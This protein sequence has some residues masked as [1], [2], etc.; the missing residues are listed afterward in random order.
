MLR[1]PPKA[2]SKPQCFSVCTPVMVDEAFI[3][4]FPELFHYTNLDA[5]RNIYS[6]Q[7]LW[8]SHYEFLNDTSEMTHFESVLRAKIAH[9][10]PDVL[11]ELSL[12]NELH[13]QDMR[14]EESHIYQILYG[15][16]KHKAF[17]KKHFDPYIVSFCAHHQTE[18]GEAEYVL[19]NGLLSQWI[20]YGGV[21]GCALVFDTRELCAAIDEEKD[22]YLV[23]IDIFPMQYL[24]NIDDADHV[25]TNFN[26]RLKN[27][28]ISV[29]QEEQN[30]EASGEFLEAVVRL[31]ERLKH[32]AFSEEREVRLSLS[33][34]LDERSIKQRDPNGTK[35][36][37]NVRYR[38]K[39]DLLMP[40]VEVFGGA[41]RLPIKRIIVGPH[42]NQSRIAKGLQRMCDGHDVEITCSE[43]P[44]VGT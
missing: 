10:F 16:H 17:F 9:V 23:D 33:L 7:A 37:R 43:T 13:D 19:D 42:P 24:R 3:E 26:Q 8:A 21:A 38:V 15:D 27:I 2:A 35:K 40:F 29:I 5:L 20:A 39:S 32:R 34:V 44:Y 14:D 12:K 22:R 41:T 18:G 36:P 4:K 11:S 25:F 31:S 28:C 1:C 30:M 6:S